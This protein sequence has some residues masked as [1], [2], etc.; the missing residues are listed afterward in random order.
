M[1][2]AL[3]N[4][5]T[6]SVT[7]IERANWSITFYDAE[8]GRH[9]TRRVWYGINSSDIYVQHRGAVYSVATEYAGKYDPQAISRYEIATPEDLASMAAE[10]I[11]H[12]TGKQC[13][14]NLTWE[15]VTRVYAYAIVCRDA[16]ANATMR[17]VV[18]G[19]LQA[20]RPAATIPPYLIYEDDPATDTAENRAAEDAANALISAYAD[21]IG[22]YPAETDP[23]FIAAYRVA[24]EEVAGAEPA[25]DQH[26]AIVADMVEAIVKQAERI[27]AERIVPEAV[28]IYGNNREDA[29]N[30]TAYTAYRLMTG[31]RMPDTPED[32]E[33]LDRIMGYAEEIVPA[34]PYPYQ[35][36]ELEEYLGSAISSYDVDAIEAE[37]TEHDPKTGRAMWTSEAVRD[38]WAICARHELKA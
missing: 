25:T 34:D 22:E 17:S 27:A 19:I 7:I 21:T 33:R 23:E 35:R 18:N 5:Y 13:A 20:S 9:Y 37:A 30:Y 26:R 32:F 38:L 8:T 10:V 28:E 36:L 6:E 12:R 1:K 29:V 14:E 15:E 16:D 31:E 4:K 11:A 3:T 2:K 24:A